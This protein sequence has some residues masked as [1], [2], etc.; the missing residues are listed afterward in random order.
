MW[1]MRIFL[2]KSDAALESGHL[3][4]TVLMAIALSSLARWSEEEG[5]AV[6]PILGV[7]KPPFRGFLEPRY[8]DLW[9]STWRGY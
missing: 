2:G 1:R 6:Y 7:G 5:I 3:A 8:M 9:I 4:S